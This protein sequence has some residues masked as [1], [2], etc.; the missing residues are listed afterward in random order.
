[1]KIFIDH[2]QSSTLKF[3]IQKKNELNLI[4]TLCINLRNIEVKPSPATLFQPM[5]SAGQSDEYC[6][7]KFGR[8]LNL[9]I[10]WKMWMKRGLESWR[11]EEY[12][13]LGLW[14]YSRDGQGIEEV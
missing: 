8:D 7:K 14:I 10:R 2:S 6:L 12:A 3:T 13:I 11:T 5:I 1:M 4:L 9:A